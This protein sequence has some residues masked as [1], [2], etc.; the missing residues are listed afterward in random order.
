M[1]A[2]TWNKVY[3]DGWVIKGAYMSTESVNEKMLLICIIGTLEAIKGGG[4]SIEEAEKFLFSP[5][6]IRRITEKRYNE[7]IINILEKGCE[8]EDI[9]SLLPQEL[10]KNLEQMKQETLIVMKSYKAFEEEPWI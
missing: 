9:V 2:R 1:D 6:M 7:S 4:L 3:K 10:E 8:L 5:Y